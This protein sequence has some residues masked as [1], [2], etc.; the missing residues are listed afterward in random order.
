MKNVSITNT[1]NELSVTLSGEIDASN[2]DEFFN[3]VSEA[4][5]AEP[6]DVHLCCADLT[7]ID[8]TTL[9]AIVKLFKRVRAENKNLRLSAV[10]P[11]IKK[12]F[13]ICALDKIM[14][15]N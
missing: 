5:S 13:S 11:R 15:I 8:S 12:L 7:F 2:A 3:E 6:K 9:G 14:E 1:E 10:Q 4:F